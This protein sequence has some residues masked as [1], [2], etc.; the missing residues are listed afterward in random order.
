MVTIF[1]FAKDRRV[2]KP[3]LVGDGNVSRL[4]I[5]NVTAHAYVGAR[6]I[7]AFKTSQLWKIGA[8]EVGESERRSR[9]GA[10]SKC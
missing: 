8:N 2:P 5:V 6:A 7:F 3:R 9:A 4:G 10:K 1:S